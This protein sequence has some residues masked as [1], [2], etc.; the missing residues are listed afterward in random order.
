MKKP[1]GITNRLFANV[2]SVVTIIKTLQPSRVSTVFCRFLLY[3]E[4]STFTILPRNVRL[5][6]LFYATTFVGNREI[7]F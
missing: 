4:Y 1:N 5:T 7:F 2:V 3:T 6:Q